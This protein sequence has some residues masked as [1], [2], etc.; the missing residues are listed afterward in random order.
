MKIMA[1][2][3]LS[4]L[5]Q[6]I[7]VNKL[8]TSCFLNEEHREIFTGK[9]ADLLDMHIKLCANE[10]EK[11]SCVTL[12]IDLCGMNLCDWITNE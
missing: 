4:G 7:R 11:H 3:I 9:N 2:L 6:G 5:A 8:T 12:G 1:L 10:S